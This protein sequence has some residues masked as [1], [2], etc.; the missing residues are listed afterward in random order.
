MKE[1]VEV[2]PEGATFLDEATV[3]RLLGDKRP[4][5]K[6]LLAAN[7]LIGV[8]HGGQWWVPA[9]FLVE[10]DSELGRQTWAVRERKQVESDEDTE[11][12]L[13]EPTHAPLMTLRGTVTLLEDGGFSMLETCTWLISEN[14]AFDGRP[15][16]ALR[17]GHHHR[18][19]QVAAALAW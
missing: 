2:L 5:V 13:P 1:N 16:D 19:N 14:D 3:A 12:P 18:V 9:D 17:A 15:I 6:Q 4:R 8:W 10:L 11:E 7:D